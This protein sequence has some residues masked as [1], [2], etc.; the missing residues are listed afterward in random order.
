M[1]RATLAGI[2]L[3]ALL[4][5]GAAIAAAPDADAPL[6]RIRQTVPL[7][8]PERW[9]YVVVDRATHRVYVAHGDHLTIVDGIHGTVAGQVT[10]FPGG[11]HGIAVASDAGRGYTDDGRAGEAGGFALTTL[12]TSHHVKVEEDADA[13]VYD[14]ASHH[15][16]VMSGNGTVSVIDPRQDATVAHIAVGGSLEYGAVDGAGALYVNGASAQQIVRI[17]TARNTVTAR[18]PVPGCQRPH[19]L[20]IDIAHHRLF[21]SCVNS[22]LAVVSTERGTVVATVPIGLGTD[23]AAFDPVRGRVF[24]SN[25]R[26]GTITVIQEKDPDTYVPLGTLRTA[27]SGRTMDL[28]PSTGSLYVVAADLAQTQAPPA[29]NGQPA[30][31]S[32]VPGS[33]KL[34]ILDPVP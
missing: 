11:T 12:K 6:Y 5:Q 2:A 32:Y 24:S 23:A 10:G 22:V 27:V 14:P 17:D 26:D 18:W 21:A 15:V 31:P 9:D 3:T 8:A 33:T 25:G 16:F 4:T 34:L 29:D 13:M 28:D 30:R 1:H 20:A 19:G 7:G